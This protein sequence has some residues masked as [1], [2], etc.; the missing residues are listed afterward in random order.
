[1]YDDAA[2]LVAAQYITEQTR[3]H[4][5]WNSFERLLKTVDLPRMPGMSGSFNEAALLL[6]QDSS[7]IEP[8]HYACTLVHFSSHIQTDPQ[9]VGNPRLL[10]AITPT[11]VKPQRSLL[12]LAANQLRHPI[13]H[14]DLSVPQPQEWGDE[15]SLERLR[16]LP[17]YL[18]VLRLAVRGL[19]FSIPMILVAAVPNRL[20]MT[21]SMR[22]SPGWWFKSRSGP[23][24]R[25]D[26]PDPAALLVQA[27]LE[28][29]FGE[30]IEYEY[31]CEKEEWEEAVLGIFGNCVPPRD[32]DAADDESDEEPG[33][34]IDPNQIPLFD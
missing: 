6:A 21:G 27:G 32:R 1:V 10:K 12:M 20:Y 7:G 11:S 4:Y 16:H 29:P 8:E 13:A 23:W 34:R 26:D 14:G 2:D 5:A 33:L 18:H 30:T 17:Q 31:G 15:D 22:P 9:W 25:A 24:G 3:L 19:L 28:A